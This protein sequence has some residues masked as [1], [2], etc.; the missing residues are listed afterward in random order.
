M[1]RVKRGYRARR[2]RK[3]VFRRTKGFRGSLHKLYRPAKQAYIKAL[4]YSTR[5]RRGR[6]REMRTLWIARINAAARLQGLSYSK[7][8][9]GL[10]KAKVSLDRRT[11]SE[12]AISD[13]SAFAKL[14]EVAKS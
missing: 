3:K 9:S 7:F 13:S 2:R 4:K 14:A 11:L 1:V 12:L 6:K 10:R 5:D 8:I